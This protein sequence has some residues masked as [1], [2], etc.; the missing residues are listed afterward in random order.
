MTVDIKDFDRCTDFISNALDRIC[1]ECEEAVKE[2]YTILILSDR[3]VSKDRLPVSAFLA[4]GAVHQFLVNKRIRM[5]TALVV[6]TAEAREVHHLCCLLGYGADAICPYLVFEIICT[7]NRANLLNTTFSNEKIFD[8][9]KI[10]VQ[11]GITRVMAKMG[12]CTLQSYKGAQIFEA[13][14]IHEEVVNKCFSG[15]PSRLG[16]V[17]FQLLSKEIHN[18]YLLA[19]G[20]INSSDNKLAVNPGIINWRRGGEKHLNDPEAIASLQDASRSNSRA[21]YKKFSQYH[22]DATRNCTLRGQMEILYNEVDKIDIDS[23]EPASEIVKRFATGAISFGS[24]SIESHKTL[25]IAMNRINAKSNTGEGGEFIERL[26]DDE[27]KEMSTRS[28]IKQIGSGRFGVTSVYIAHANDLEIKMALGAAP[29]E[30][31][32]SGYNI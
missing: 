12:I 26:V 25:A 6:E 11:A 2:E 7:L 13:V 9:Y 14:G 28:A 17:T 22:T 30:G 4:L 27:N 18:R 31:G 10:A 24:I 20:S 21:A 32:G 16:G 29:G 15:T 19:Y 3:N 23:V 1:N 8:N 5:K